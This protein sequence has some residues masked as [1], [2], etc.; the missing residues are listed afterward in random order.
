MNRYTDFYLL[1]VECNDIFE[2][3]DSLARTLYDFLQ[4]FL[5][6]LT[7]LTQD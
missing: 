5:L 4:L 1:V 7:V 3:L 6:P 2:N